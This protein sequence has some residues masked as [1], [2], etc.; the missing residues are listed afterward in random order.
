MKLSGCTIELT[1][2]NEPLGIA[3]EGGAQKGKTSL[4]DVLILEVGS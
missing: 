2:T 3:M 4:P 1:L